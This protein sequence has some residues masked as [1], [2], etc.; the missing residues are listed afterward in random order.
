MRL[1]KTG[2][3]QAQ[4]ATLLG[5]SQGAVNKI[6]SQRSKNTSYIIVDRLRELAEQLCPESQRKRRGANK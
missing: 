4:I 2:L 3:T 5:I 1:E 6:K